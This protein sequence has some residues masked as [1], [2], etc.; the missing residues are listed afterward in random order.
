MRARVLLITA[1][2]M[3]VESDAQPAGV[4]SAGQASVAAGISHVGIV[5]RDI[6]PAIE[7]IASLTGAEKAAI[8]SEGRTQ[9]GAGR[10][11]RVRLSNIVLE[12]LQP[13]ADAPSFIQAR[14]IGVHHLGLENGPAVSMTD[15]VNRL[16]QLGGNVVASDPDRTFV[17]L[18]PRLGPLLE[19]VSPTLRDRLYR[20]GMPK[21]RLNAA[22]PFAQPTCVT[23][24]G[25]VVR[26]MERARQTYAEF[27][28][29]ALP[30]IQPL[31]AAT[32]SARY[33]F[34]KLQNVTV[35]LL[36]QAAGVRG[37]YADFLG[38]DTQR[39]HHIG[40][41]LR[42]RETSYRGVPQQ[43]AWLEQHGGKMGVNAGHF[44]YVDV[45]LGVFIEA[46]AEEAIDRV[47]PCQ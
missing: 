25:I 3:V 39:V 7:L 19:I 1:L 43:I 30:P 36:Q 16:V 13:A 5:V 33:T 41:H 29:M 2:T 27:L 47:Y 35:E 24:V 10:T 32:G 28:G 12:L 31:E 6:G 37:A 4:Q 46:L 20:T 26:D 14:G 8:Q 22:S 42:G 15:Q 23:H 9:T 40:L 38:T 44:A 45:G 11:A 34:F 17:D 18:A 21:P